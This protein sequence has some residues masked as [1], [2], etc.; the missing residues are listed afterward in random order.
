VAERWICGWAV[1]SGSGGALSSDKSEFLHKRNAKENEEWM[2]QWIMRLLTPFIGQMREGRLYRGG[3]TVH[4]E[5]SYSMLKFRREER[6]ERRLF[7]KEK[8]G[9]EMALGSHVKGRSEDAAVWRRPTAK[10]GQRLN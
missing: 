8:G 9:C 1:R 4:G 7:Q 2:W 3:E 10:V 6:K 5:W